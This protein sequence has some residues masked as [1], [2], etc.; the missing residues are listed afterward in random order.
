VT[1][2]PGVPGQNT[3]DPASIFYLHCQVKI[4]EK[5]YDPSY[6]LIYNNLLEV[7]KTGIDG[8]YIGRNVPANQREFRIMKT[9]AA[10][11]LKQTPP[12]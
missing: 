7:Q 12:D 4:G 11:H 10:L 5:I 3:T 9:P 6:G 1:D 2:A 8:F